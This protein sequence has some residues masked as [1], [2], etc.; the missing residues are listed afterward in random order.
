MNLNISLRTRSNVVGIFLLIAYGMLVSIITDSKTFVLVADLISGIA[1]I[2]IAVLMYPLLNGAGQK[3]AKFYL[4]FKWIEGILM[5]AGGFFFLDDKTQYLRDAI[6]SSVHTYVFILS[7]LAFYIL[8]YRTEIIPRFISIWGVLG[9][10]ASIISNGFHLLSMN[11]PLID[12]LL[13]LIITNEVFL[14]IWLFVK[15]FKDN[16]ERGLELR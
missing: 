6:Y 1:V 16:N 8:L 14:A 9:I 10:F 5:I 15:G 13:V 12:F 2:G 11:I 7:A 3:I 4:I